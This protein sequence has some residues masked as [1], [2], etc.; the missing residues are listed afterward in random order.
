MHRRANGK[1]HLGKSHIEAEAETDEFAILIR[2]GAAIAGVMD[3]GVRANGRNIIRATH[4][5]GE[6]QIQFGF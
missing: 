5:I 3:G 2:V 1:C 4:M 6:L